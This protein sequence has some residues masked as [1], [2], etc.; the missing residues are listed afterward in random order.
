MLSSI[1][2]KKI[3]SGVIQEQ[4]IEDLLVN[5]NILIEQV[6]N[7]DLTTKFVNVKPGRYKFL[8]L[9]NSNLNLISYDLRVEPLIIETDNFQQ[10]NFFLSFTQKA[11]LDLMLEFEHQ[12][13]IIK[14]SLKLKEAQN[15]RTES[16]MMEEELFFEENVKKKKK[17][18]ALFKSGELE[19]G[20]Y[21]LVVEY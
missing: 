2:Q 14:V 21:S 20:I 12:T 13:P 4:E 17:Q 9:Q 1:V 8:I 16:S 6:P 18:F 15:E 3:T 7:Q 5:K 19:P 10:H 11:L